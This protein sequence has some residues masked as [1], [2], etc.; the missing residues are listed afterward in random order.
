MD[1]HDA[2][3]AGVMPKH[4][5]PKPAP[6]DAHDALALGVATR[7]LLQDKAGEF[8][9]PAFFMTDARPGQADAHDALAV[10]R[11]TAGD[12]RTKVAVSVLNDGSQ[13][14]LMRMMLEP[15]PG[16]PSQTPGHQ[17]RSSRCS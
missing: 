11:A 6:A 16:C 3:A 17:A 1:A 10:R 8:L 13:D 7:W 4:Q 15:W 14:E 12:Y 5:G 9:C 2:G